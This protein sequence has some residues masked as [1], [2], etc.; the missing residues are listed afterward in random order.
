MMYFEI[1]NSGCQG[2]YYQF[3]HF[4][5]NTTVITRGEGGKFLSGVL[6]S[7]IGMVPSGYDVLGNVSGFKSLGFGGGDG[8]HDTYETLVFP[9]IDVKERGTFQADNE[10]ATWCGCHRIASY[11]E[12]QC[13]RY[14]SGGEAT[15][16]HNV[17]VQE[18]I[19]KLT[20]GWVYEDPFS[21][22]EGEV[23]T[24]DELAEQGIIVIDG[25]KARH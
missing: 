6:V 3:A 15:K 16:G 5:L 23:I 9:I 12:L 2:H 19:T 14:D 13:N 4:H 25:G 21:D 18:W 10:E 22:C 1:K 20:D 7:T 11:L 24:D 17:L 8:K